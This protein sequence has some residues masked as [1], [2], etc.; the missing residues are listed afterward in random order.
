MV[1]F[2]QQ[3]YTR[4]KQCIDAVKNGMAAQN[5]RHPVS[6]TRDR[7]REMFFFLLNLGCI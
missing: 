4:T 1:M 6:P 2:F 5:A 7:D 3:V